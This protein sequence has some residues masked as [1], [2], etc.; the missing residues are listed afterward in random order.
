MKKSNLFA[1]SLAVLL[2]TGCSQNEVTETSADANPQIGFS[3]YT[4]TPTRGVEVDNTSIKDDPTDANKYGGFGIMGYFTGSKTWEQVDKGTVTPSFMH[5]QMV[6]WDGTLNS[7]AGGWAYSPVKY[8]PNNLDD[9]ISF[10]A[11]A[12]YE[13]DWENGTKTG[14]IT[15]SASKTGIPSI[16]FKLKAADKLDKMVDLVVADAKDQQY[17]TNNGKISFQFEHTLARLSFKAQL[18]DGKFDSMDGTESFVYITRMW[19]VGTTHTNAADNLSMLYPQGTKVNTGSKFYTTASWSELHWKYDAA[20]VA[21]ADFSLDNILNLE[22]PGI[23][24]SNPVTGHSGTVRG[25]KLTKNSQTTA[26]SLFPDK[27]FLYLIPIGETNADNSQNSGCAK[28]DIQIGFHYDIVTKDK[29]TANQYVASHAEA[30]IQLPA[31]HMK[32]KESYV[33]TLKV[34]LHEITI[35]KAEVS[36]WT[37]NN[38]EV[39]VN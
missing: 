16:T 13:S 34:N 39:G 23:T 12:P 24:E 29:T 26:V 14:I 27:Q 10:F 36:A 38:T 28:G 20:T 8:W 15:S 3:V 11:Y 2:M 22:S 9:K 6:G 35:D 5:N 31:T 21:K 30:F 19:I 33:Y 37:P 32:R 18:G 17:S 7:N 25:I 4:G 1:A